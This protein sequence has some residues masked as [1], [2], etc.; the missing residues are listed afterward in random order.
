MEPT[1]MASRDA[2]GANLQASRSELPA[3]MT[4]E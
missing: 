4:C 3:A 1:V 2:A